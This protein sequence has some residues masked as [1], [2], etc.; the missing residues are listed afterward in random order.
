MAELQQTL[1]LMVTIQFLQVLQL[2][3]VE[4]AACSRTMRVQLVVLVAVAVVE[5]ALAFNPILVQLEQQDKDLL[6]VTADI[7]AVLL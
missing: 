4:R 7:L 3:A 2:L 1:G 5:T 6:G